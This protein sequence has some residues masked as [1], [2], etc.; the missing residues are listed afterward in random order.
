MKETLPPEGI[1]RQGLPWASFTQMFSTVVPAEVLTGPAAVATV[2]DLATMRPIVIGV[3]LWK[4]TAKFVIV[5][6]QFASRTSGALAM[7][8][9]WTLALP[10]MR[11]VRLPGSVKS[12]PSDALPPAGNE[13]LFGLGMAMVAEP[14][15][16]VRLPE[17]V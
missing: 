8:S 14:L 16:K 17:R 10:V 4:E 15:F 1:A 3:M 9:H 5:D 12:M 13:T 7:P 2:L 11:T 6:V